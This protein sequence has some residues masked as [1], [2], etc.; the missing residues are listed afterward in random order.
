MLSSN[1]MGLHSHIYATHTSSLVTLTVLCY[2]QSYVM[3]DVARV[4]CM[5]GWIEM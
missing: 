1:F 3:H 4:V 5:V 2:I